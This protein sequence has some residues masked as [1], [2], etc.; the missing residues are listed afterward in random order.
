M[1]NKKKHNKKK[2]ESNQRINSHSRVYI[3]CYLHVTLIEQIYFELVQRL[4]TKFRF[5]IKQKKSF[6]FITLNSI[7]LSN[8]FMFSDVN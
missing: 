8:S 6:V 5:S 7:L 4:I 1:K 3:Q 2:D